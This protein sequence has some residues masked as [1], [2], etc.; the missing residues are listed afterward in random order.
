MKQRAL[1]LSF[2]ISLNFIFSVLGMEQT[3]PIETKKLLEKGLQEECLHD[4]QLA[5]HENAALLGKP[6]FAQIISEQS[7][8]DFEGELR[9]ILAEF[10]AE[11][12]RIV[13]AQ[14]PTY[15][16]KQLDEQKTFKALVEYLINGFN[17][18]IQNS[19]PRSVNAYKEPAENNELHYC[20]I[21]AGA[22][23]T[24]MIDP[25]NVVALS[26]LRSIIQNIIL[27]TLQIWNPL[28]SLAKEHQGRFLWNFVHFG[29]ILGMPVIMALYAGFL[30]YRPIA[31]H[32]VH[33]LL[34][35]LKVEAVPLYALTIIFCIICASKYY[36]TGSVFRRF[37]HNAA[38]I[39][40][41]LNGVISSLDK[42]LDNLSKSRTLMDLQACQL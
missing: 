39:S 22:N 35:E 7:L 29:H 32:N 6:T 8:A 16:L 18:T 11:I 26:R 40:E 13:H 3:E 41:N 1:H 5:V 23:G 4:S 10:K 30:L 14:Y 36:T 9:I 37:D 2:L 17:L 15:K 20:F 19:I 38:M 25:T 28:R 33:L 42:L 12:R 34:E 21:L 27:Y 24:N 31:S